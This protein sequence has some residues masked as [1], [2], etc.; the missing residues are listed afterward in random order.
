MCRADDD[1][2][3][4][5]SSDLMLCV[6]RRGLKLHCYVPWSTVRPT[7]QHAVAQKANR[8]DARANRF[9]ANVFH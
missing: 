1:L 2:I 4:R 9:N 8:L 5:S 7:P 6:L 3:D